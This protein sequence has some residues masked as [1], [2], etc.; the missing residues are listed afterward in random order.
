MQTTIDKFGRV[1]I[2][3]EVREDLRL[4]P[5]TVLKI[6]EQEEKI[7]LQPIEEESSLVVK[8]GILIFSG[9]AAGDIA[10]TVRAHRGERLIKIGFTAKK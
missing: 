4:Q 6:E 7:L 5:G 9:T 8:D 1:V 10:G 2:P 3:K